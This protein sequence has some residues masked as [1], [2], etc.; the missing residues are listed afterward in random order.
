MVS[1]SSFA[2][3]NFL[4]GYATFIKRFCRDAKSAKKVY[5]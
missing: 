3:N 5:L 4:E 1:D 2:N